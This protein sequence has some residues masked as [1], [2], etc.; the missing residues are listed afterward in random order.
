M[1][2]E[3]CEEGYAPSPA[4]MPLVGKAIGGVLVAVKVYSGPKGHRRLKAKA[5]TYANTEGNFIFDFGDDKL[6][7]GDVVEFSYSLPVKR[8]HK[9]KGM[10]P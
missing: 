5:E 1:S 9:K 6:K 4:S 3:N 2:C 7:D 10:L 8:E